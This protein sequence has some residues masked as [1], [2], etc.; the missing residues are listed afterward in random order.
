[1][2]DD[3]ENKG[4]SS[5]DQSKKVSTKCREYCV[6]YVPIRTRKLP[7]SYLKFQISDGS[8]NFKSEM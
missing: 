4:Q 7:I 2:L 5:F 3:A 6:N 8:P 1:M